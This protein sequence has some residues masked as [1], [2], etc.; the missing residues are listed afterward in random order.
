MD[1]ALVMNCRMIRVGSHGYNGKED[2]GKLLAKVRKDYETVEK[3][4]REKG[5][6]A[7]IEIHMGTIAPSASA[8][9]RLVDGFDPKCI[10]AM[11][12][13]GNMVHEGME[14]WQMGVEILGPYLRHVHA[15]NYGWYK[16]DGKWR[17]QPTA[18]EEGIA[19]FKRVLLALHKT[20]YNGY[21]DLEDFRG[22]YCVKPVGIT[23]EEK[24][25][26]AIAFLKSA[27]AEITA[28]P[29]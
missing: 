21:I 28:K 10:C 24:L 11:L 23:T 4:A 20:G 18:L 25:A 13:P 7:V 22:G 5:V 29:A 17:P 15:K 27:L 1:A 9:R 2:Y 26:Q 3:I 19:D 8:M 14:N 6:A 16:Q 12:D